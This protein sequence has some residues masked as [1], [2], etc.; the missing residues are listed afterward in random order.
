MLDLSSLRKFM[1]M[2]VVL[3]AIFLLAPVTASAHAGHNEPKASV[4]VAHI[5]DNSGY[6]LPIQLVAHS[7][8][9]LQ[10]GALLAILDIGQNGEGACGSGC[11]FNMGCC[12]ASLLVKAPHLDPPVGMPLLVP[13]RP[14]A[15]SSACTLSLLEP[16]KLLV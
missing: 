14:T 6:I 1:G 8:G 3:S 7:L 11:C 13:Y 2:I 9:A 15:P 5:N 12:G 10:A 4:S 16:P